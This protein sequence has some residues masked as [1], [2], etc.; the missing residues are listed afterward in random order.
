MLL[1]TMLL[2]TLLTAIDV[3]TLLALQAVCVHGQMAQRRSVWTWKYDLVCTVG[4]VA[5][6][7]LLAG[8]LYHAAPCVGSQLLVFGVQ[9]GEQL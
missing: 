6:P 9:V 5:Q 7:W 3:P 8:G 1:G 4:P 2:D